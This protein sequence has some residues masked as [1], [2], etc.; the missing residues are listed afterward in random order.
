MMFPHS[1]MGPD[2]SGYYQQTDAQDFASLPPIVNMMG[3]SSEI[4]NNSTDV[5]DGSASNPN[6]SRGYVKT[7]ELIILDCLLITRQSISLAYFP[8]A[9]VS[10]THAC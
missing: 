1:G 2:P 8:L 5:L 10:A 3:C 7:V 6:I 4:E 9:S